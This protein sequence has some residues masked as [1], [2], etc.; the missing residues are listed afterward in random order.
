[1][2]DAV[3]LQAG[4]TADHGLWPIKTQIRNC[5]DISSDVFPVFLMIDWVPSRL[6]AVVFVL[7]LTACFLLHIVLPNTYWCH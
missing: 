3:V 1:M 7:G 4:Q 6:S 2:K 5:L